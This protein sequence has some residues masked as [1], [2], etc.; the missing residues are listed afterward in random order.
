MDVRRRWFRL[1]TAV[2][3]AVG[4]AGQP[5]GSPA[6]AQRPTLYMWNEGPSVRLLQSRLAQWDYYR[7]PIDGVLGRDTYRAVLLFQ[8]RNGL[9]P[10]GIV[11]PA[12]WR[13]LGVWDTA[14][15]ATAGRPAA[16]S[17]DL[18]LL[19]RIVHAEAEA[20]PYL[21]KVAVAAVI[22]NRV[23]HPSFPD[24]LA[25]VIYEP[26]AFEPVENGWMWARNPDREAY[27]A[28]RDA[29]NGWDPTYGALFFWAP[30]KVRA[31]NWVWTREI[32]LQIGNH[33]FAR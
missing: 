25:G 7:G 20:E 28:A 13:A 15:P 33:V 21:G 14:A 17:D 22:L 4:L 29:L 3:V 2:V 19:A 6:E 18:D 11:G 10:D 32:T 27:R 16:R 5:A 8:S 30:A 1:F 24:T 12:T 9:T 23:D 26:G 31:G